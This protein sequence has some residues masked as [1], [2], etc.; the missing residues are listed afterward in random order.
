M[1]LG[2]F[3]FAGPGRVCIGLFFHTAGL[4]T[5]TAPTKPPLSRFVHWCDFMQSP[6]CCPTCGKALQTRQVCHVVFTM[7]FVTYQDWKCASQ[8]EMQHETSCTPLTRPLTQLFKHPNQICLVYQQ[9]EAPQRHNVHCLTVH[10]SYYF[11][12]ESLEE[13]RC[14]SRISDRETYENVHR[15]RKRRKTRRELTLA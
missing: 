3:T 5:G 14:L 9:C 15:R 8:H 7:P 2:L 12:K 11:C 4:G 10:S 6:I 1:F 13:S